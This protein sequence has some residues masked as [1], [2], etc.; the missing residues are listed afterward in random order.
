M[1]NEKKLVFGDIQ[2]EAAQDQSSL[3]D[4]HSNEWAHAGVA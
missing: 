1:K 4:H 3:I 2:N